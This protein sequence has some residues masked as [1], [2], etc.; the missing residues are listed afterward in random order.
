MSYSTDE[1]KS[2]NDRFFEELLQGTGF[3]WKL[4]YT[5]QEKEDRL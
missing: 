2:E 4:L 5:Y 1:E 3:E